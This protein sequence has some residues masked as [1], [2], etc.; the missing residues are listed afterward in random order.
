MSKA[1][2]AR[3]ERDRLEQLAAH[4]RPWAGDLAMTLSTSS[5]GD[6]ELELV[7]R[8]HPKISRTV[9]ARMYDDGEVV[10]FTKYYGVVVGDT[11]QEKAETLAWALDV[12]KG[13]RAWGRP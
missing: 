4:L 8:R 9:K 2:A 3:T 1:I 7:N 13:R 5:D 10:I 12:R 11:L 6:A